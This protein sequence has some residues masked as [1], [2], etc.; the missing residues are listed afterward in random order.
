MPVGKYLLRLL[1][2][3]P[4]INE[5]YSPLWATIYTTTY[6]VLTSMSSTHQPDGIQ[7]EATA[8]RNDTKETEHEDHNLKPEDHAISV[9]L[10][11]LRGLTTE[12]RNQIERRMV[13][14]IDCIVL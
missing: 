5:S 3:Y 12:D 6:R 8:I 1:S 13:R 10:D 9:M 14:K 4:F 7:I 11:S 2:N